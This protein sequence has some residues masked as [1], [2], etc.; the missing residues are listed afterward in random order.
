MCIYK[1]TRTHTHASSKPYSKGPGVFG[2][3]AAASAS[4]LLSVRGASPGI[5][6]GFRGLGFR[7]SGFDEGLRFRVYEVRVLK[8]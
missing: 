5:P 8:F 1:Y 7:A 4:V 3:I 6:S 2:R